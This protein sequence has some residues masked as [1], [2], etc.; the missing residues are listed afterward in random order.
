MSYPPELWRRECERSIER[1]RE[2]RAYVGPHPWPT[3]RQWICALLVVAA[4]LLVLRLLLVI[5]LPS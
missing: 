1:S 5:Q 4:V 3:G 2:R